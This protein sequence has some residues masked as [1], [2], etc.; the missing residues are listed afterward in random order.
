MK[1]DT[2]PTMQELVRR[3]MAE[4]GDI[5]EATYDHM[6]DDMELSA[7][8]EVSAKKSKSKQAKILPTGITTLESRKPLCH[9]VPVREDNLQQQ[10]RH[11]DMRTHRIT[12]PRTITK[13]ARTS[14]PLYDP[15]ASSWMT[16]NVAGPV[17][18][19]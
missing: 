14:S 15:N 12:A 1:T 11:A 7:R 6:A 10:C 17:P 13:R 8:E 9:I 19:L 2:T 16:A 18:P 5:S 4:K 3:L